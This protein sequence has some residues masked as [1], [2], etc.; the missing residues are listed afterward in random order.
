MK[1]RPKV[2]GVFIKYGHKY[3]RDYGLE[4]GP[5]GQD[6]SAWW[7]EVA[8]TAHAG[9]GGTTGI[10]TLIVLM[11]WWCGLVRD[12]PESERAKYVSIVEDLNCGVLAAL[13]STG[14]PLGSSTT[15]LLPTA[16]PT[17]SQPNKRPTKRAAT[18]DH[19]SRKR[20]RT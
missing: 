8:A 5:L 19:P 2:I 13:R 12:Q 16:L 15:D 9:Y 18:E 17:S 1:N 14:T 6:I 10:Y 11:T 3:T 7:R 20:Q 4:A